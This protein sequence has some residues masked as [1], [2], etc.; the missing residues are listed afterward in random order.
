MVAVLVM[1]MLV[2]RKVLV[3]QNLVAQLLRVENVVHELIFPEEAKVDITEIAPLEQKVWA[4]SVWGAYPS[5]LLQDR[6]DVR[7]LIICH[8]NLLHLV[9]YRS[10]GGCT[11][12]Q[13]EYTDNRQDVDVRVFFCELV[14]H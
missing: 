3:Q 7:E 4:V 9:T 11:G 5:S 2:E 12:N 1:V 14:R 8:K 13:R 6:D 10:Y